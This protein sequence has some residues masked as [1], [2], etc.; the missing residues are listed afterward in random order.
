MRM[1]NRD[2][3]AVMNVLADGGRA[4]YE[5]EF[6]RHE[7]ILVGCTLKWRVCR[8]DVPITGDSVKAM[9]ITDSNKLPETVDIIPELLGGHWTVKYQGAN[10]PLQAIVSNKNFLGYVY[11]DK[12]KEFLHTT[13]RLFRHEDR[14]FEHTY[15][16]DGTIERCHLVR[17]KGERHG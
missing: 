8:Q 5:K 10:V 3:N 14:L 12:G 6:D 7:V 16:H 4:W 2:I 1:E 13:C 17:M 11:L 9:W 15:N